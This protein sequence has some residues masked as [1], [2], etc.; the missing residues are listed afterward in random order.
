ME[1]GRVD[2]YSAEG[3]RKEARCSLN[4]SVG[5]KLW[6][7]NIHVTAHSDRSNYHEQAFHGPRIH[8][9]FENQTGEV[10]SNE[11][12]KQ[13]CRE[14]QCRGQRAVNTPASSGCV[15]P[16]TAISSRTFFVPWVGYAANVAQHKRARMLTDKFAP[17]ENRQH[18]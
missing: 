7:N 18:T 13:Q 4:F 8:T 2:A 5:S 3:I 15:W 12:S 6:S 17:R 1:T 9:S 14:Q 11:W 10:P 16:T